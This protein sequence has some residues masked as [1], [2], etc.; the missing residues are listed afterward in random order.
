M[1]EAARS[2]LRATA[3]W[4]VL[5]G[6]GYAVRAACRY[7]R[8]RS[9]EEL[10]GVLGEARAAGL[11]VTFRGAGR[12]YGDA[13]LNRDGLVVDV[14]G[15][16][17]VLSWDPRGGILDAEA[18]L[19]IEGLW[20]HTIADGFW[21]A[22]VPGTMYPTLGG[23]LSMNIHG[24]NNFQ[25]GP[26]GDHVIDF[27]LLT[28]DGAVLR[29]SRDTSADVFHAA[30]AG[31][32]LLGAVTR[33][34]L[35]LKHVHSGQLRVEPILGRSI[36]EMLDVFEAR[37]ATCDYLVGWVDC[38]AGGA[39]LG[40]GAVHAASYLAE[41]QDPDPTAT[42]RV[43]AQGLPPRILGFPRDHLWKLLRPFTNDPGVA[44]VNYGKFLSSHLEHGRPYRQSHVQFAF[45]LD[46]I[47]NWRLAYGRAGFVQHQIFVP[48][49]EARACI[50][51]VLA[52]CQRTG[53][54]SYLGVLKRHRPDAFLMSHAL[55]GYS[56]AMDFPA[57]D[58]EALR[59]TAAAVTARVLDAGGKFYFAKDALI[60][61]ADV[62]RAYGREALDR[63]AA[64]RRR[65]DPDGLFTSDLARRVLGG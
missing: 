48:Q 57:R 42:L 53:V 5:D 14:T 30:I 20:R 61:P 38:F 4:R 15:M 55:D 59:R 35:R 25:V 46:Y 7:A 17:H 32:G 50:R 64:M 40:R 37:L 39:G 9:V 63:F 29:C 6:F 3:P 10:T 2:T 16:Q 58:L 56:L 31:M 22:V 60:G 18:G 51:D 44:L 49:A 21:P 65:L 1:G 19:T 54:R 13:A 33:V 27:D 24:K 45:L 34:K 62:E 36:D 43:D 8:P 23:C 26:F 47:A 12:S 11:R 28:A 52:L 41:G